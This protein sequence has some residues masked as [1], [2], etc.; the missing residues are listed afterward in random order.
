M[1]IY[2]QKGYHLS[3]LRPL[4]C[5]VGFSFFVRTNL[6]FLFSHP[7]SMFVFVA[8]SLDLAWHHQI[9]KIPSLFPLWLS[10]GL[11]WTAR[12]T[13]WWLQFL[14]AYFN[15]NNVINFFVNDTNNCV[16]C[17]RSEDCCTWGWWRKPFYNYSLLGCLLCLKVQ[18]KLHPCHS[19]NHFFVFF[20]SIF[21]FP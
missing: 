11:R 3:F 12:Y 9:Y 17:I 18:Q 14:S 16:D 5:T 20:V 15:L 10:F 4:K 7:M 1:T 21:K 19:E 2:H 6:L 8:R 13:S